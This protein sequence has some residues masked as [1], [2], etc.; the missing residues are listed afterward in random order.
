L[1]RYFGEAITSC[2]T[3]CDV[4]ASW[5][6]LAA[7]RTRGKPVGPK[8]KRERPVPFGSRDD[9]SDMP[10]VDAPENPAGEVVRFLELKAFRKKLAER[11][12]VPPYV[13]FTD[14]TLLAVAQQLPRTEEALSRI[15]GI[16]AKKL[17]RW[18]LELLAA[19][20]DMH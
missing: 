11:E 3:S 7:P 9:A 12:R 15:P 17:A 18:G 20:R 4:C 5:D 19:I 1:A 14:A 13:V 8:P 10:Y 2:S 6:I 16:G